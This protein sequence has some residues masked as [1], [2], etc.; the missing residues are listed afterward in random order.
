MVATA[1][2]R[3]LAFILPSHQLTK[4]RR[5]EKELDQTVAGWNR[6]VAWLRWMAEFQS[7]G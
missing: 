3:D 6:I 2:Q 1:L 5:R 7:A 4:S